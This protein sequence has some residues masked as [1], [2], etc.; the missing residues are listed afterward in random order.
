LHFL[1]LRLFPDE[2][3]FF[4]IAGLTSAVA[5]IYFAGK[6]E[7]GFNPFYLSLGVTAGIQGL[8]MRTL[9]SAADRG[10]RIAPRE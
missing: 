9:L 1:A 8:F 2:V 7:D 10:Y 3:L 5:L 4:A 6:G